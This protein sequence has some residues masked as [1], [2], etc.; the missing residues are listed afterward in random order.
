MK[1]IIISAIAIFFFSSLAITAQP[2][3]GLGDKCCDGPRMKE[4]MI[5]K[6]N[7][8]DEQKDKIAQLKLEAQKQSLEFKNEIEK[9]HLSIKQE[10][11]KDNVNED[12]ILKLAN[13]NGE[14]KNK[15]KNVHIKTWFKIYNLLNADQK[16]EFKKSFGRMMDEAQKMKRRMKE[17]PPKRRGGPRN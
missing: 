4:R 3:M 12:A 1:R 14:L 13:R 2:K 17:H 7:L 8:S 16:K 15:I 9:N 5:E 11:L 10:L 6:L